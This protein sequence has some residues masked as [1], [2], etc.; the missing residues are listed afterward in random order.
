[1]IPETLPNAN[2]SDLVIVRCGDELDP[3]FLAYYVNSVAVHHVNSHLVGA[4]QQHFN[5]G[6]A[7][8]LL[9]RLPEL[10]EQRAIV[11]ILSTL[12][13]RIELNRR[14]NETLV[15]MAM[16]QSCYGLRAKVGSRGFFTYYATY[17]AAFDDFNREREEELKE[18]VFN[19]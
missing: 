15:P 5:V 4:V 1:V 8:K 12:D 13:D 17:Q 6:S 2:C 14:M 10:A 3:K 19:D 18:S 7:R 11:H 16:N 9:I